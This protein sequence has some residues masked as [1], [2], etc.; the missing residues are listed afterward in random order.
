MTNVGIESKRKKLKK[1]KVVLKV[2][3]TCYERAKTNH[4]QKKKKK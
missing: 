3:A 4:I 2:K 1:W